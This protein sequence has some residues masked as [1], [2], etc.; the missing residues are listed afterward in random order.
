M[1]F[2]EILCDSLRFSGGVVYIIS[3]VLT[4]SGILP[5]L[6]KLLENSLLADGFMEI[7]FDLFLLRITT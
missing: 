5:I 4:L 6:W 3:F 7:S 1:R 2:F